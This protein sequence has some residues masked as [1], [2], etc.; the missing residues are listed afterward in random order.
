MVLIGGFWLGQRYSKK[1]REKSAGELE[2]SSPFF[3][4]PLFLWQRE[5]KP[6]EVSGEN[7]RRHELG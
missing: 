2:G 1:T 5:K 3:R 7:V 4:S 6:I